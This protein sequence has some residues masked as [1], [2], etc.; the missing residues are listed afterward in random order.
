[1]HSMSPVSKRIF[2]AIRSQPLGQTFSVANTRSFSNKSDCKARRAVRYRFCLEVREV[3]ALTAVSQ[4]ALQIGEE[5][6]R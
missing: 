6:T 4:W 2:G 1:A 5:A 3:A